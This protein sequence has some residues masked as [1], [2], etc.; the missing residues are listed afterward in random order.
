M[1]KK[2]TAKKKNPGNTLG[3]IIGSVLR[4]LVLFFGFFLKIIFKIF[5]L[6]GL[7]I[8][9]VYALFG[10]LLYLA[11][12]FNPFDFGSWGTLY[13]C[14]TIVCV[15][16]AA[17]VA[18][19]NLIVKP[20]R[21]VYQ[22]YKHPFWEKNRLDAIEQEK[23]FE[24]NVGK[25][26]TVRQYKKDKKF[27]PPEI[28]AFDENDLSAPIETKDK[29]SSFLLPIEDFNAR[30]EEEKKAKKYSLDLDWLPKKEEKEPQKTVIKA[31]PSAET[32]EIYFSN[33]EPD[34]LVH[35]YTDRFELFRVAGTKTIPVGVE[36]K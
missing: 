26:N 9:L 15:I 22:G 14:G 24:K 6:F 30:T 33:L 35:E 10:V 34:I 11:F 36:Y 31:T 18:V 8:P 16:A 3:V 32:P 17:V 2:E 23:E 19:R 21:S 13:L 28:A 20:A 7:W 25:W 4:S 1:K 27:Q 29:F 5:T 12:D